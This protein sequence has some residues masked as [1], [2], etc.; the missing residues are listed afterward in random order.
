MQSPDEPFP[1]HVRSREIE[2]LFAIT[3]ANR[4]EATTD[5]RNVAEQRALERAGSGGKVSCAGRRHRSGA[6]H[7]VDLYARPRRDG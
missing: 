4:A 1:D 6:W 5:V 7:D 3:E 2:H